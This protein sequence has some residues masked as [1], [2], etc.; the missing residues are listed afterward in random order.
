M[1]HIEVR[2][3]DLSQTRAV[4]AAPP[5]LAPDAVRLQID[6]FS[7][8][9]NNVTY[10]AFGSGPLGYWDFFPTEAPWGRPPCWGFATVQ[11]S[12]AEG[13]EP[14]ARVW[15]Y[16]PIATHLDV[17]PT[18]IFERGFTDDAPHRR[19]KASVYNQYLSTALDPAYEAGRDAE[20]TLFRPLYATGW[21]AADCIRRTDPAPASVVVSSASSKT[22][23][24]T[25]H[26]LKRAGGEVLI[27]GLTS[28]ANADYVRGTGLYDR[29][30]PYDEVAALTAPAPAVFVDY[31]GA[32]HVRAAAHAALGS[33]LVRS[34]TIGKTDWDA[35]PAAARPADAAGVAPEFFFVPDYAAG[36]VAADGPGLMTAMQQDMRAFYSASTALVTPTTLKG[37]AAIEAGWRRLLDG[38]VPPQEGLVCAW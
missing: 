37:A 7:L 15:G 28:K 18:K 20:Q 16:F 12:N 8:T 22:A 3:D 4:V 30:V 35:A 6:L 13:V 33:G 25:V 23:L 36:R 29:V 21:W 26:Q 9:A 34:L 19:R 2:K 11:A 1:I 24:S 31:L 17:T 5:P 10:A 38:A 27:I 14:G 32:D